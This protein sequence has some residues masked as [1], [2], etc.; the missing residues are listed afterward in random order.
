M[1][2]LALLLLASATLASS[3]AS[4]QEPASPLASSDIGVA[5]GLVTADTTVLSPDGTSAGP[6][7]IA[8]YLDALRAA[9]PEARFEISGAQV[10]GGL[11]IVDWQGT[12]G[13]TVVSSGRTLITFD[14]GRIVRLAFL[15]LGS[16]APV[17]GGPAPTA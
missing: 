2:I 17:D 1:M 7:A 15:D 12:V 9:H 3:R 11:M 13:D 4:A 10:I 16:V 8:A 6:D 14:D 5:R